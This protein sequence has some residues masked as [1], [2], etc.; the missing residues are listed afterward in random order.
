MPD[1]E[2]AP[3]LPSRDISTDP[4]E[5]RARERWIYNEQRHFARRAG[6][7]IDLRLSRPRDGISYSWVVHDIPKPGESVL[8]LKQPD[9]T[10]PYS[11]QFEGIIEKGYGAGKVEMKKGPVPMEVITS[12]QDRLT[13]SVYDKRLPEDFYLFR[14]EKGGPNAW[15]LRNFTPTEERY[16]VSERKKYESLDIDKIDISDPSISLSP[17]YDGA[18]AEIHL[19]PGRRPRVI[20]TRKPKAGGIID[21]SAKFKELLDFKVPRNVGPV[22][23]AGEILALNK[24]GRFAGANVTAGILNSETL[25]AREKAVQVGSIEN[26]IFDIVRGMKADAPY[27]EKLDFI[28]YV[29]SIVPNMRPAEVATT[30]RDKAKLINRIVSGKHPHTKEGLVSSVAG[31]SGIKLIKHKITPEHDIYVRDVLPGAGKLKDS[32]GAIAY[33][34]TPRG[35]IVGRVGTG[36]SDRSRRLIWKRRN[37][38]FGSVISVKSMG[39][40]SKTKAL[41]APVFLRL[42]PNKNPLISPDLLELLDG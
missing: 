1:K 28:R 5:I 32:M 11:T 4:P 2:F 14:W 6:E 26:F 23:L 17:K 16:P 39:E 9:H 27:E 7:H 8:A 25:K 30:Q 37:E 38:L 12:K 21:H 34:H 10:I 35:P 3:G 41:R 15:L 22:V 33:S 18:S 40:Y 13:F 19:L 20:S 31:D 29:S 24:K 36:F 42:H